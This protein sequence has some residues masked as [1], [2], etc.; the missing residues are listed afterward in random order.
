MFRIVARLRRRARTMSRRNEQQADEF[1]TRVMRRT[2]LP[3]LGILVFF[4]ADAHWAGYPSADED[5]HPL[6]GA[7]V[8][9]LAGAV[10]D[11]GLATGLRA[12]AE[13]LDDADIRAGFVAT[14]KAADAST[15]VPR[16]PGALPR[17][18]PG[19]GAEAARLAFQ[20]RYVGESVQSADPRPF[21]VDTVL[22]RRGDRVN[23]R[24][25]FGLGVGTLEGVV[26]GN[27][28]RFSWSWAG[29]YGRGVF[30]ASPDGQGFSG[31]WGYRESADNAGSWKGQRKN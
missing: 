25:T 9:T 26:A 3:P 16:R 28:L 24:Y 29:N 10:D 11:R 17:P 4:M 23:G 18:S 7:R 12:L 14:G 13:L 20:G 5:T 15:L 22:E 31:T 2:P 8:R 19:P 21:P 1:A 6:S 27:T 30:E